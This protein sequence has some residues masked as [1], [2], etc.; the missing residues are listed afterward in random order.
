MRRI[1]AAPLAGRRRQPAATSARVRR[2]R[3]HPR[4]HAVLQV[5]YSHNRRIE[6][7]RLEAAPIGSLPMA[8]GTRLAAG[9]S[10]L[11]DVTVVIEIDAD[12]GG[13]LRPRRGELR[14][15]AQAARLVTRAAFAICQRSSS[16]TG[17][18]GDRRGRSREGDFSGRIGEP[19]I[20]AASGTRAPPAACDPTRPDRD[21]AFTAQRFDSR[22]VVWPLRALQTDPMRGAP[23]RRPATTAGVG[24]ANTAM[25]NRRGRPRLR[26]PVNR[27]RRALRSG[28]A[29]RFDRDCRD[30]PGS[31]TR[32]SATPP[33][34]RGPRSTR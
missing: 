9:L 33:R 10:G 30:V 20:A 5:S 8:G 27:T 34:R 1:T 17:G 12:S 4:T 13:G 24:R 31:R 21:T 23:R 18:R 19:S 25:V 2:S 28:Y 32:I 15:A 29:D 22:P 16:Q 26:D 7:Q 6:R 11:D 3:S 14:V